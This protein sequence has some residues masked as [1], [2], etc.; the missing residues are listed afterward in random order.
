MSISSRLRR[1]GR[2]LHPLAHCLRGAF[3]AR[4]IG[5]A[6]VLL[7]SLPMA[8]TAHPHIFVATG[9]RLVV[10]EAGL[11]QAI[12]VTWSYDDFYSL[13][14]FEDRGLDGDMDGV[15]SAEERADL[16]G[17]DLNW[18][19]GFEGDLYLSRAGAAVALG[20]PE[21]L[22]TEVDAGL[23][24]TRHRRALLSPQPAAGLMIQAYDPTYYTA[25]SL[26]LG[27]DVEGA[28]T[29]TV[30]PP[31]LDRAYTMVEELL[32]AMPADQAEDAYPAVGKAFATTVHI[33]CEQQG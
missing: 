7:A 12:E 18:S 22:S 31:D 1:T 8:A 15:L 5:C 4:R 24:V 10:D 28:C 21:H 9:L 2:V 25:Y 27:V 14:I 32:Y 19:E 23:I 6:A 16:Q 26:D 20:A 3:A 17:F 30:E 29:A 13:L 11:A 33:D